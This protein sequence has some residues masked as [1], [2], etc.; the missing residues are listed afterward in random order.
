R[1]H[2]SFSRDWSSDVCSSDL[3]TDLILTQALTLVEDARCTCG[4][5][6]WADECLNPDLQDVWEP[7]VGTHWRQWALAKGR[8]DYA[9]ELKARSEERRVGE[10]CRCR[11]A[12]RP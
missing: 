1:R 10:E 5:N 9:E 8:E 3:E 7:R 12:A 4:C 2:T 11:G 6:G